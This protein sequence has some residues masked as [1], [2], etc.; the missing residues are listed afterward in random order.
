MLTA[1]G[2]EFDGLA[3]SAT[4]QGFAHRIQS[5]KAAIHIGNRNQHALLPGDLRQ[6]VDALGAGAQRLLDEYVQ[7]GRRQAYG[8]FDVQVRG[9][10]DHGQIWRRC[11][12]GAGL[13]CD[14]ELGETGHVVPPGN[15]RPQHGS[16]STNDASARPVA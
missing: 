6:P 11:G 9:R 16:I 4:Q 15:R 1:D 12:S 3:K 8:N 5:R 10:R 7:T 13:Q 2:H 14:V